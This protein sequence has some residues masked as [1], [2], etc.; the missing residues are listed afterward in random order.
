MYSCVWEITA[1]DLQGICLL[2]IIRF[3]DSESELQGFGC[4]RWF[5]R[6]RHEHWPLAGDELDRSLPIERG[7]GC[8]RRLKPKVG[9]QPTH[10][11]SSSVLSEPSALVL[12]G[13]LKDGL[14]KTVGGW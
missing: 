7:Q 13:E 3:Q 8:L 10:R 4:G 12:A 11:R 6:Q 9:A 5:P 1:L 14:V 2:D